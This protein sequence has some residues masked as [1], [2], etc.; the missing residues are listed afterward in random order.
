MGKRKAAE[1]SVP[2]NETKKQKKLP[3]KLANTTTRCGPKSLEEIDVRFEE[4]EAILNSEMDTNRAL[5]TKKSSPQPKRIQEFFHKKKTGGHTP[6]PGTQAEKGGNLPNLNETICPPSQGTVGSVINPSLRQRTLQPE[7]APSTSYPL[8]PEIRLVPNI[9]C[10]NWFGPLS[11]EG[12][13]CTVY[14][15]SMAEQDTED[16]LLP[17]IPDNYSGSEQLVSGTSVS[18]I[19]QKVDEVRILVSQLFKFLQGKTVFHNGCRCQ[20]AE[21]TEREGIKQAKSFPSTSVY[22]G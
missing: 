2:L 1:L 6:D 22:G 11:E 17:N 3:R 15:H 5:P 4:V 21:S 18:L 14:E 16:V 12:D 19:L 10:E 8:S 20:Q 7:D 13:L 9:P